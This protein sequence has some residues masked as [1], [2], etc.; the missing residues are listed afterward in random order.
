MAEDR[1]FAASSVQTVAEG[2]GSWALDFLTF[3]L[4]G[5]GL[6]GYFAP[7]DNNLIPKRG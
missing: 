7:V 6:S 4:L 2:A 3:L 1:D 5:L